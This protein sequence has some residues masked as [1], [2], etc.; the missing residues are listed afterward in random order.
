[1]AKT[2]EQFYKELGAKGLAARKENIH[3][4]K[5]LTYLKKLLSKNKNILDLACGFGRFTIPLAKQGYNIEGIDISPNLLKEAKKRAKE[6][7]LKITFKLGDMRKLPYKDKSFDIILC[8]WSAFIELHKKQDQIK[9]LK[10]M[11]RIIKK[12]GFALLEMPKPRRTKKKVVVSEIDGVTA[13]P[14]F[15]QNK[16]TLKDLMKKVY[17][18]KYKIFVD[19]F[20]GR[21]RLFLQFW[22]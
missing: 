1:M 10:E 3:T 12:D 8:M 22:K 14:M 4:K 19:N 13:T 16:T 15:V 2:S 11:L 7:N 5:E 9:A 6:E 21:E 18:K 17:V 20:G